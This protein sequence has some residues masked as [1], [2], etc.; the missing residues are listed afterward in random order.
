M[1]LSNWFEISFGYDVSASILIW[2][3]AGA[4]VSLEFVECL[5][6][7]KTPW[8]WSNEMN[9]IERLSAVVLHLAGHLKTL[10]VI[11]TNWRIVILESWKIQIMYEPIGSR[12]DII[13]FKLTPRVDSI[14]KTNWCMICCLWLCRIYDC[15][16]LKSC[17]IY[18]I[19][20][21]RRAADLLYTSNWNV[22]TYV[23]SKYGQH[24]VS[25][26]DETI[27]GDDG[28]TFC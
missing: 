16:R 20:I 12:N 21:S 22:Y 2:A 15:P 14:D 18:P 4:F 17:S 9:L 28:H 1:N 6:A 3:A 26:L 19:Y 8:L 5:V 11:Q 7:V 13:N 24:I 27:F 10:I 25:Y 23:T